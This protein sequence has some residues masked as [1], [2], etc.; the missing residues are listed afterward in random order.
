MSY[1]AAG[2]IARSIV[3]AGWMI[4]QAILLASVTTL[5][6]RRQDFAEACALISKTMEP[7]K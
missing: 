5:N 6:P 2:L 7:F 1:E 4:A 3:A